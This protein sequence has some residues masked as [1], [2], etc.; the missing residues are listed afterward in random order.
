M[1]NLQRGITVKKDKSQEQISS[2][3]QAIQQETN[4]NGTNSFNKGLFV[5]IYNVSLEEGIRSD[6]GLLKKASRSNETLKSLM[7]QKAHNEAIAEMEKQEILIKGEGFD[8]AKYFTKEFENKI[9]NT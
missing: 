2:K 6:R 5:D 3:N 1:D 9:Q 8:R 7:S 4:L